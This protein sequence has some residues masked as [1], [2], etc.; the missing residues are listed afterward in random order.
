MTGAVA[1]ADEGLQACFE[2]AEAL[3]STRGLALTRLPNAPDRC[4][5]L[6]VIGDFTEWTLDV[7]CSWPRTTKLPNITL[8]WPRELLAH[9][10]HGGL[11]C[12]TDSAGL[13][14]DQERQADVIALTVLQTFD[15]LERSAADARGARTEFLNELEGYWSALPRVTVG[16][17]AAEVDANDRFLTSYTDMAGKRP[18]WYFVERGGL[19]PTEFPVARLT[20]MRTLYLA[21]DEA[22]LPPQPDE[23]LEPAFVERLRSVLGPAQEALWQQ[24]IASAPKKERKLYAVLVSVPRPAGGRSLIGMSFYLR[25]GRIDP[26]SPVT[27]IS[28]FRHTVAYMRERGGAL[29]AVATKHVVIFGC[30]SVGSEVADA[31]ASSGVGRLT[32]VDPDHMSEDN[33]F[34]HALGRNRIGWFKVHAL[35]DELLGKYPGLAVEDANIDAVGWL[36]KEGIDGVDGIVVA[37][38]LPTLERDIALRLRLMAKPLAVVYAWLEP[39]DLGGHSLLFESRGVGCLHCVYRN[40]EGDEAL[41]PQT[42]FLGPG[43]AVTR[44][45]TGCASIFVP[46]GAIQSRRTA[47]MAAEQLLQ[48]LTGAA[49]PRY[50]FWAGDGTEA[51][52][53]GLSTT[54]WWADA[55]STPAAEATRRLFGRPCRRCRGET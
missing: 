32:L 21:L 7:D 37:L 26:K 23:D 36:S 43:Q 12:L 28:P 40:D 15:L 34:R 29:E 17:S 50:S 1:Q 18:F 8:R 54:A 46:Y 6:Q 55:Q 51:R 53:Q 4:L 11:V 22:V 31:L 33:V 9:V 25:G 38:G 19:I 13:S 5:R 24:L 44:N 14:I 48:G 20:K 2:R 10:G 49:A 45:L 52:K 42:A 35:R 47:L 16:R 39:L 41:V 30:G 3:F 27:P